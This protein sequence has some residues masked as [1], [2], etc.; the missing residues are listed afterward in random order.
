MKTPIQTLAIL[1]ANISLSFIVASNV[2][3]DS[4]AKQ[5]ATILVPV[6]GTVVSVD[7]TPAANAN[8]HFGLPFGKLDT[9]VSTEDDGNF[10]TSI[11]VI[12]AALPAVVIRSQSA[13]GEQL[14][15]DRF[16]GAEETVKTEGIEIQLIQART[17]RVQVVDAS[18]KPIED[19]SVA[20][21]LNW[22]STL[23]DIRSDESGVAEFRYPET[24]R[25][26]SIVAWKDNVGL[27]YRVYSLSRL[28]QADALAEIPEFPSD[29]SETLTLE[30][31]SP[32]KVRVVDDSGE[33][34]ANV[35]TYVWL[36]QKK[37]EANYLNLS[38]FTENFAQDTDDDG[39]VVFN[40]IPSW[41]ESILQIWPNTDDFVRSRGTYDPS[42]GDGTTTIKLERLVP[43]RG[44]VTDTD[45]NPV[46]GINIVAT[47]AGYTMDDCRATTSTDEEGSYELKVAPEQVYLVVAKD[48]QFA[49]APHT[50]FAVR[51]NESIENK[52]F[53]LRDATRV[54]GTLTEEQSGELLPN[55]RVVVY[56]YG[57]DL[58]S[59]DGV[60]LANPENSRRWVR[61]MTVFSEMTNADGQFEVSLG[62]GQ[63]DIRPPH[64]GE[65]KTFE[66]AGQSELKINITTVIQKT[67]ELTGMVTEEE[68][69]EPIANAKLAGVSQNFSGKDWTATTNDE[70]K[71]RV[72]R[73]SDS[74]YVH[75]TNRDQ[76]LGAISIVTPDQMQL[77]VQLKPTGSVTGQLF[78]DETKEPWPNQEINYGIDVPSVKG[79]TWST[80]FGGRVI[81]DV[82]GN[83]EIDGLVGGRDYSV[84]LGRTDDGYYWALPDFS[85]EAGES[86]DLGDVQTPPA[87][88]PYVPLTL[89]QRTTQAFEVKGTPIERLQRSEKS[90]KLVN[91]HL[92]IVFGKPEDPRI[93]RLMEIRFEDSDFRDLRDEFRVMAIPTDEERKESAN[94]LAEEIEESIDDERANFLLV[95]LDADG[96]KVDVLDSHA[97]CIDGEL[98]KEKLLESLRNHKPEMPDA[99]TV[100]KDALRKAGEEDKRLIVQETATWCGPCQLLTR[101]LNANREWEKDYI[102]VKM[103]HRLGGARELMKEIRDGAEGGIPW[104]AILDTEGEKLITSNESESGDNV[105]Y[106]SSESGQKH[107]FKMINET[108]QR[109]T[110]E[111]VE[112]FVEKLK[113]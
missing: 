11:E 47:G 7:G 91:Q 24:E 99:R 76:D 32:L 93:N 68:T 98:S 49:S 62:D 75:V 112:A 66:I 46:K 58:H 15:V 79:N 61:P 38:Y 55:E 83:F 6:S 25:I 107:F 5:P 78:T 86:K 27:D 109:M 42:A 70:G 51:A 59:L 44:Q 45:G 85:V 90:I 95:V 13:D 92:L 36:L 106:P 22:P 30:G 17:G 113:S 102:L 20:V 82:D 103:D 16:S 97:L 72:L 3:A 1:V 54:F 77:D 64:R 48:D 26:E 69:G 18:G 110:E 4:S 34:I 50:G 40:W 21:Q 2:T 53:V 37:S 41:Q 33:P 88:K 67:V 9:K 105:G 80:R 23:S 57:T 52:D 101:F 104:L 74:T 65:S 39:E 43:I 81:T 84:N 31:T 89:E 19:A 108:R 100:L 29:A 8:V 63:F 60:E 96:K 111:E 14:S 71:F 35:S 12:K 73:S 28:Q 87:P 56:Q 10:S 94:A